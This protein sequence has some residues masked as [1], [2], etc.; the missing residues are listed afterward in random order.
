MKTH[1]MK[2]HT[3]QI[4]A[5]SFDNNAILKAGGVKRIHDGW[6]TCHFNGMYL[7]CSTITSTKRNKKGEL[8]YA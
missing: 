3:M 4:E 5:G 7:G 8:R 6:Y 2:T 1:T